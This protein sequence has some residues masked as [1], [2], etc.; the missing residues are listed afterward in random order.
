MVLLKAR[1]IS[2]D[3]G[4]LEGRMLEVAIAFFQGEIGFHFV[5]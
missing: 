4:V 1:S 3:I 2:A 5:T